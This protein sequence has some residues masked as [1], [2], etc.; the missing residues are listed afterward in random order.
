MTN[1]ET[2]SVLLVE[3]NPGDARLIRAYLEGSSIYQFELSH[4]TDLGN[5]ISVLEKRV[6]DAILLD[7][8]LPDS[9]GFASLESL[10]EQARDVPIIV[11]TGLDD[12]EIAL[13]VVQHGAQ[14]YLVKDRIDE[15]SV[16][17]IIRYA[18]ERFGIQGKLEERE[19][20]L[21]NLMGN[22]EGMVY[23]CH[24][25]PRWPMVFVS[26]GAKP[27]T[28][29]EP[30][31]LKVG[32][33][34]SYG[35]IIHPEDRDRVWD[36]VQEAV[37][38]GSSFKLQYRI[39]TKDDR[40]K[41]V[42]EEGNAIGERDGQIM[43]EGY[44]SDITERVQSKKDLE[45]SE[46]RYR[47]LAETAQDYI[48][49]HGLDGQIIYI[50][51]AGLRFSGYSKEEIQG[52]SVREFVAQDDMESL[53]TRRDERIEGEQSQKLYRTEFINEE[54]EHVPV[55]VSSSPLASDDQ[56]EAVLLVARDIRDRLQA[57]Q[58]LR[59]SE[60]KYRNLFESIR[61]ALLIANPDREIIDC[62]P[63]FTDVFGY[64]LEEI[65]GKQ[66]SIVYENIQQ[67]Q[68][69]GRM[70]EEH[71]GEENFF[72]T[73][74]YRKKSGRVFPGETSVFSLRDEEGNVEA[75]AGLVRDITDRIEAQEKLEDSEE[76]YRS[77]FESV[78]IGLYRTTV[79]GDLTD[80][81][82]AL[83]NMLDY[84]DRETLLELNAR[85]LY[86]DP[87]DEQKWL[88]S[89]DKKGIVRGFETQFKRYDGKTIWVQDNTRT[90][91]NDEGQPVAYQ[92]SLED[93][94]RR[95]RS[96]EELERRSRQMEALR[97][98]GI[99]LTSELDLEDLL[100]DLVHLVVDLVDGVAGSF[101][102]IDADRE[103]VNL[104]VFMGYSEL[105][106]KTAVSK[107]DDLVGQVWEREGCIVVDDYAAWEDHD[108]DWKEIIGHR[109]VVGVPVI[110][111]QEFLGVLGVH[112]E[113]GLTFSE[114]EIQ[115]LEL[116]ATQAAVA[117]HNAQL[118]ENAQ[119]RLGRLQ[120]LRE[121]DQTISGSLDLKTT[122]NVLLDRL[123][124]N[125]GVDAGSILL[126][127]PQLQTLDYV[128]G[129]GFRTE[130]IP[131]SDLRIGEGQAGKAALERK[132]IHIPDLTLETVHFQRAKLIRREDF[133][134][135]FG[136]PLI[137]KGEIVGVL[138]VFHREMLEPS[139]EWINFLET[140]AGQAAIAIDRLNL[141]NNLERSNMELIRA[142]NEVIEG[143]ARALELRD[144]E[145]EGHSRRVEH[146]TLTMAR[147]MGLKESEI[148][149][150]RQGALLHDIGKMGVPD[151]ILQKPGK[152]TEEEWE[153]MRK[154]PTFAYE[155]LSPIDH[156]KPALHIPYCH[157]EKWDGSGYP[158]GLQ[159]EEIP[160]AARIFA[161]VDVWDALRSDRPYRDAWSD[162]KALAYIK[163]QSGAHFDPRVVDVFLK[164][165][166]EL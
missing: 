165:L 100:Q 71:D 15:F 101:N 134:S 132:T 98:M 37:A 130:A 143:W 89:M 46:R 17:R 48:V 96:Q 66:T 135:Y 65:R 42:W 76:R 119:E 114:Q 85:D 55:E 163:D 103:V 79:A 7:L 122:L 154:H 121:I 10:Q 99:N 104:E 82:E 156:L 158:R 31:E 131:E 62:N 41:W 106:E 140:L 27:L 161:V 60:E 52:K 3:D 44:I 75:F 77:L 21:R 109:A 128:S 144:Q 1:R 54:G 2:I 166:G 112:R 30:D 102:H 47:L 26:Q 69:L 38:E 137:A 68:E 151:R 19:R 13:K 74:N 72:Y 9:R 95:K 105:P 56:V 133:V 116:F 157:H 125:L 29:Y 36:E 49:V 14:D 4:A 28:G 164:V 22:L 32:G 147:E 35:D 90:I 141:F 59:E 70:L 138:E 73:V 146:L 24:N 92:G 107:G 84:P 57:E 63:A 43:L 23:R 117:I 113:P 20:Q 34:A 149:D 6:Y 108:P 145:T 91:F 139:T 127:E 159:G 126:Y 93:I 81:N 64:T 155:M 129:F 115:L 33:K 78:P 86:V 40:L 80:V 16:P 150:V 25:D 162:D 148:A 11:L 45:E 39:K 110:W 12:E 8:G 94:T 58:A 153:V 53:N 50:N 160:L 136:V 152:L 124:H 120:A 142:Y 67:Y 5:A 18:V 83:V 88:A 97:E 123:L 51:Q 87:V 118:F 61:D 111:R